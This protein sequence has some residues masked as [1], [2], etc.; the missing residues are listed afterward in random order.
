MTKHT[1]QISM[2]AETK[3]NLM[4]AANTESDLAG[5]RVSESEIV[6]RALDAYLRREYPA[7]YEEEK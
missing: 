5:K 7:L 2:D 6:R 1:Q 3:T 4:T